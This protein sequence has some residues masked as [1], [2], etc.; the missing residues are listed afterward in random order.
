MAI[1]RVHQK[2]YLIIKPELFESAG[3]IF[4]GTNIQITCQGERHL[5][6]ALGD[7]YHFCH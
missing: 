3:S 7:N 5:G 1:I 4:E 6:A 2:A